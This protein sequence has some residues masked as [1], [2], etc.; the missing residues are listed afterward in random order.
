V[1]HCLGILLIL[2]SGL[3]LAGCRSAPESWRNPAAS[4]PASPTISELPSMTQP[5]PPAQP[6]PTVIAGPITITYWEDETD[7]GDVVLDELAAAFM[8]ENPG[9]QV[10]RIHFGTEDLR[11]QYRVA[12]LDSDAPEMVRGAG[13]L[14]APFGELEIVRPLEEILPP[15]TLDQFF[16][17][18][19]AAARVHGN[20]W[21][22]PDNYGNQLM[23]IYNKQ[24][25]E[26]VPGDTDSWVA[27]LKTLTHP[28]QG[29]YGLVY[30]L[31]EPFW[32]IPWL[33]GFG[34]W[35]LD[36]AGNPALATESMVHAL[37]FLQDLK[38]V[39]KV[40]PAD[41][42]YDSAYDLFRSGKAAYVI[43]GEWNLDRYLGSGV[44]LGVAAL[45]RV[46]RTGLF[47]SPL[48]LGKYWFISRGATGSHLDAAVKFVEFMTSAQAQEGWASKAGRLPSSKEAARSEVITQDPIKSASVDQLSKGRGLQSIPEMYCAWGAMRAPLAGVM[49]DKMT[50]D[51]A[52]QAM[53]EEAER[54]I[55]DM[56]AEEAP[57][58]GQ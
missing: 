1:K 46:T 40:V 19:L 31:K 52:S 43:D 37:Q 48:T 42:N 24:L 53:Q 57:D 17:G 38:L 8:K 47:P 4:P 58:V 35:P 39:H 56:N 22:V 18:A 2:A 50:P 15:S 45:P 10:E 9:L 33:G 55:A 28:E 14:A 34:G 27:Q 12:V 23:L 7:E 51:A 11:Q 3:A 13:E 41:V 49:D 36:E 54:C 20:L 32:L 44:D 5:A 6:T 26:K 30:D 16:P 25:V 29:Q 21:G